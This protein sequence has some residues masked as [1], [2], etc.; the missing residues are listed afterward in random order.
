M[1][2]HV[3]GK[4]GRTHGNIIALFRGLAAARGKALGYDFTVVIVLD[5]QRDGAPPTPTLRA[6]WRLLGLDESSPVAVE[7]GCRVWRFCFGQIPA[8]LYAKGDKLRP[9]K[10]YSQLLFHDIVCD[11]ALP[12]WAYLC[13]DA[14]VA[15]TV[16]NA[17]RL[18]DCLAAKPNCGGM[19]GV[20]SPCNHDIYTNW[21]VAR[22]VFQYYHNGNSCRAVDVL[23]GVSTLLWGPF[24]ALR[25]SAFKAVREEFSWVPDADDIPG[26]L[27]LDLGED[28]SLTMC[29]LRGGHEPSFCKQAFAGTIV[30]DTL[31]SYLDQQKRWCKTGIVGYLDIVL[32]PRRYLFSR[33]R[34]SWAVVQYFQ[35]V[36]SLLD[37]LTGTGWALAM[38]ARGI[39][40]MHG[41]EAGGSAQLVLA[42]LAAYVV[43]FAVMCMRVQSAG[44]WRG[45]HLMVHMLLM[46]SLTQWG[47]WRFWLRHTYIAFFPD[48]AVSQFFSIA[49]WIGTA[50]MCMTTAYIIALCC[51]YLPQRRWLGMWYS[52]ALYT[53]TDSLQ[54]IVIP[55]FALATLDI[56]RW[57]TRGVNHT[58]SEARPTGCAASGKLPCYHVEGGLPR[59]DHRRLCSARTYKL[60]ALGA[61]LSFNIGLAALLT[62]LDQIKLPGSRM[63]VFDIAEI[64]GYAFQTTR[65]FMM[66][67]TLVTAHQ[68]HDQK[69]ASSADDSADDS[70]VGA[71]VRHHYVLA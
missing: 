55:V 11:Y 26:N 57:C 15:A 71:A 43:Y 44:K 42:A 16:D 24:V 7:R 25:H 32:R 1:Y 60:T 38:A 39:A 50:F 3:Q 17:R 70:S 61:F 28:L 21:V 14:D 33:S 63:T 66:V 36:A 51:V 34:S 37:V 27:L 53:F 8:A 48:E 19:A 49:S 65:L 40:D 35:L 12:P 10:R 9:G 45:A 13:L 29:A 52:A 22:Q 47:L 6:L 56:Y 2:M 46:C 23:S 67:V 30:P 18:L 20:I 58:N 69:G 68:Q 59:P 64:A 41:N 5:G 54:R 31:A 62:T 4:R